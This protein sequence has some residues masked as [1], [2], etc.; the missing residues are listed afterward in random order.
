MRTQSEPALAK[1]PFFLADLALFLVA[2]VVCYQST[3]PMSLNALLLMSGCVALGAVLTILPFILQYRAAANLAQAGSL[4]ET[5]AQIQHLER[6][7][8]QISNATAQWLN[9]QEQAEK[10]AVGAKEIT[11]RMMAEAKAF[12]EFVQRTNDKEKATLRL[13]VDKLRRV[14]TDWLQVLI[15]MLDHVYALHQA[16]VRSRQATVIEQV[17][18]FQNACRD[19]ARRV[20]LTAFVPADS[21]PFDAQ[22]HQAHEN[23]GTPVPNATISE[24]IAAGYTF[25]GKVI[26]PALVRLHA[27]GKPASNVPPPPSEETAQS[28]LPLESVN[29]AG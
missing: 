9:V 12:G 16:A 1:W 20:G 17:G 8:G 27:N 6:I 11:D 10:T 28:Q 24:T 4:A 3:R 7:A 21:E 13:E 2:G 22:R 18:H 23:N 26:R 14:E 29:S 15:R 19:A 25:Q 5:V